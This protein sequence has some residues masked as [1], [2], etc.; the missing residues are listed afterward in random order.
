MDTSWSRLLRRLPSRPA[1]CLPPIKEIHY[2]GGISEIETVTLAKSKFKASPREELRAE[3]GTEIEN[4]TGGEIECKTCVIVKSV[5]G[6]RIRN[7][8]DIV[9]V[10]DADI[11]ILALKV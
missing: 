11:P 4:T 6:V 1:C 5:R 2:C 7:S 9:I 3:F 8:N 10:K